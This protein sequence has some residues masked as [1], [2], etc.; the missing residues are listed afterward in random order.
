MNWTSTLSS[1]LSVSFSFFPKASLFW[2]H[3][4]WVE[5]ECSFMYIYPNRHMFLCTFPSLCCFC[6]Q[7][8]PNIMCIFP[9]DFFSAL[10]PI[11]PLGILIVG[12]FNLM[13]CLEENSTSFPEKVKHNLWCK[14]QRDASLFQKSYQ[15]APSTCFWEITLHLISKREWLLPLIMY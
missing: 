15:S 9:C 6:K 1:S 11:K 14:P 12:A 4:L 8:C 7:F 3:F 5:K 10:F 2:P 13:H